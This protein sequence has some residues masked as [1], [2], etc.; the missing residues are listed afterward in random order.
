MAGYGVKPWTVLQDLSQLQRDYP[1]SWQTFLGNTGI[2]QNFGSAD[3]ATC[4]YMSKLC[5]E[6]ETLGQSLPE[7]SERER[8]SG[9]IGLNRS[10]T[11]TPLLRPDE[12]RRFFARQHASALIAVPGEHPIAIKRANYFDP[13]HKRIFG[14]LYD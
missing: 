8:G 1:K 14:G 2:I 6:S 13:A 10:V 3:E 12:V 4:T 9:K 5:G 11:V 7:L